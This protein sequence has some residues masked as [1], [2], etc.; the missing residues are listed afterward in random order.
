[1]A[2]KGGYWVQTDI[3]DEVVTYSFES[4]KPRKLCKGIPWLYCPR[5]GLMYLKNQITRWC[6]KMGCDYEYHPQYKQMLKKLTKRR[7]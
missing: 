6:I 2:Q 3:K 7:A 4:H 1:M 5:C